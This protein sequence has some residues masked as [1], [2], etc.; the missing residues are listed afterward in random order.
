MLRKVQS[1]AASRPAN[2]FKTRLLA[3]IQLARRYP[4][5]IALY[6]F[7]S[8]VASFILVDRQDRLASLIAIL[9]LVT[10]LFLMLES[11]FNQ[12]LARWFGIELPSWLLR[13][14]TQMIH[15]QSL[16]FVLPF[17]AMSTAWD[18]G[19]LVFTGLLGIA[20]L[21]SVIDPLYYDWLAPRRSLYL[22]FHSLTLFAVML[23]A[24]PIILHLTTAQSYQLALL[25]TVLL[26]FP[27]LAASLRLPPRWRLLAVPLLTASL[28]AA[29]WLARPWVP[30]ATLRLD[31]MAISLQLNN[32]TRAPGASLEQLT[33][34]QMRRR[35]L[36]AFTAITAPR[37]LKERIY[38]VW[39]HNGREI[40]RI[41]LD[42]QGGTSGGYRAWSYKQNFPSDSLGDWQVDVVT[43]GGQ[44]I[45]VLR[46]NVGA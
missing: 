32:R 9:M 1:L 2:F 29:G 30:P 17:F 28:L 24:L 26:A 10:W 31:Q 33:P 38:H 34:S 19:Q 14:V 44:L 12:R 7:A 5:V 43:D 8:G 13:F 37:G 39:R 25:I 40:D 42:I 11:A 20:A 16:F 41:A 36:Y 3:L 35:G 22:L 4:W 46:F 18:S 6:G 15:Q 45:G 23:T 21:I 27:T